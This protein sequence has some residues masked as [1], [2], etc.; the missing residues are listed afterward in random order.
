M[1]VAVFGL[2]DSSFIFFE[3]LFFLLSKSKRLTSQGDKIRLKYTVL[4][5]LGN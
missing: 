3:M 5:R 4:A 2:V 1:F